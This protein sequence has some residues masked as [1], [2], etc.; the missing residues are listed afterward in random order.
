MTVQKTRIRQEI[1]EYEATHTPAG[2]EPVM[3]T[4]DMDIIEPM[5]MVTLTVG[6]LNDAIKNQSPECIRDWEKT[7]F[8][9]RAVIDEAFPPPKRGTQPMGFCMACTVEGSGPDD[10][11]THQRIMQA[12]MVVDALL[13]LYPSGDMD[14]DD[15]E[16]E[17]PDPNEGMVEVEDDKS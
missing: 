5:A 11:C 8:K 10:L 4:D 17:M 14:I 12:S 7:M 16:G 6:R 13:R 2:D 9:L 15:D 1:E 3:T